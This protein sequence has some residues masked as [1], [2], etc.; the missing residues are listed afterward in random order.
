VVQGE[1]ES[2]KLVMKIQFQME[3]RAR[4]TSCSSPHTIA[5][6]RSHLFQRYRIRHTVTTS[7]RY[8]WSNSTMLPLLLLLL[9][10]IT[11]ARPWRSIDDAL[12]PLVAQMQPEPWT[13]VTTGHLGRMLIPRIAGTENK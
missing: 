11:S 7:V 2:V 9:A 12:L 4:R 6:G 13:D 3:S 10:A 5:V 1:L 8:S